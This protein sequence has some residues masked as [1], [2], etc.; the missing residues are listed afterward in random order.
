[1]IAFGG[2]TK[3]AFL[4]IA[5]H[6]VRGLRRY[7]VELPDGE[8]RPSQVETRRGNPVYLPG[9]LDGVDVLFATIAQPHDF[10]QRENMV[11][12]RFQY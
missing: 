1:M 10:L 4:I 2:V 12:A 6:R 7:A 8:G 5:V 3:C 9:T 11:P